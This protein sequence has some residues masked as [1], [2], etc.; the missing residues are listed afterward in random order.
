MADSADGAD[1]SP[2]HPTTATPVGG[3]SAIPTPANNVGGGT[4]WGDKGFTKGGIDQPSEGEGHVSVR[5]GDISEPE[6][7][8][9]AKT[10]YLLKN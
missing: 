4:G 8:S 7:L 2:N 10:Q 5:D 1:S 9:Q 6:A 3:T